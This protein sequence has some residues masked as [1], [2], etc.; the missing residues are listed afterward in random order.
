MEDDRATPHAAW[1]ETG[2]SVVSLGQCIRINHGV[3]ERQ[4]YTCD[5]SLRLESSSERLDI[6][7]L[8]PTSLES[9]NK[10]DTISRLARLHSSH[11]STAIALLLSDEPFRN[12]SGKGPLDALLD[13]QVMSVFV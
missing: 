9:T 1:D 8:S 2:R 7:L 10:Q 6:L 5:F 4:L 12:A 13:L 11:S 3:A